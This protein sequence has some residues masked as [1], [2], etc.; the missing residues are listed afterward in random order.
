M[1]MSTVLIKESGMPLLVEHSIPIPLYDLGIVLMY[2]QEDKDGS[3]HINKEG[4]VI[5]YE[6]C[7][8][9]FKDTQTNKYETTV[10]IQYHLDNGD[11]VYEDLVKEG[12]SDIIEEDVI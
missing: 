10:A 5:G 9:E 2:D 11:M 1:Q 4:V 8:Y 3:K 12:Y 7:V 6:V